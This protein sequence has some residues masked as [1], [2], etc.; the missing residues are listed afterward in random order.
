M[1]GGA[2]KGA[3]R[4][5]GS[6]GKRTR[7]IAEQAAAEGVTPLEFMLK[8]MRDERQD[9]RFRAEMA[10][11]A[12]PFIHPRLEAI[13]HVP[14]DGA[15]LE[16]A[17]VSANERA[18]RIAFALELGARALQKASRTSREAIEEEPA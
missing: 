3:G 15:P 10:R 14:S 5:K 11:A 2:R 6:L 7:A 18:R 9:L 4:P 1:K 17:S 13:A 8:I 12:A 16:A